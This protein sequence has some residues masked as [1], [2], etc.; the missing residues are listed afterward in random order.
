M[1]HSLQVRCSDRIRA[2]LPLARKFACII[3]QLI[4]RLFMGW[5][6]GCLLLDRKTC[7]VAF[8]I[9]GIA[10]ETCFCRKGGGWVP[11]DAIEFIFE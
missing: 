2:S 8:G 1:E 4:G 10:S 5:L 9:V 7:I 11:H 3:G 6:L